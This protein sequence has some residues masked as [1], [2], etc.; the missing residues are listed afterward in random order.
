MYDPATGRQVP[1]V[2]R[3]SHKEDDPDRG[4]K[5][6]FGIFALVVLL[7]TCGFSGG[8]MIAVI[9]AALGV[10]GVL[11]GIFA[12]CIYDDQRRFRR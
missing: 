7:L 11:A 9:L 2:P 12:L 1:D 10:A 5:R 8:N 6:G 4:F 3:P